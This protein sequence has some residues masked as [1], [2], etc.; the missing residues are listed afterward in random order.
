MITWLGLLTEGILQR[1]DN[2]ELRHFCTTSTFSWAVVLPGPDRSVVL[3][4][5]TWLIQG[6]FI[7]SAGITVEALK[8]VAGQCAC[9]CG[10]SGLG[11]WCW[12]A[13]KCCVMMLMSCCPPRGC[14]SCLCGLCKMKWIEQMLY[15]NADDVLYEFIRVETYWQPRVRFSVSSLFSLERLLL[16]WQWSRGG[17][18][19]HDKCSYRSMQLHSSTE[20]KCEL[21][22][23]QFLKCWTDELY[24]F[25]LVA[26]C[27]NLRVRNSE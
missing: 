24:P 19:T 13:L 25:I 22:Q 2:T 21:L 11:D 5:F 10:D 8:G 20:Q 6:K 7:T 17:R 27:C 23:D 15:Q 14:P 18:C 16:W 9:R 4:L 3:H 1:S 12:G 26:C